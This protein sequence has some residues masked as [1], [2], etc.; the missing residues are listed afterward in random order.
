MTYMD[1][2]RTSPTGWLAEFVASTGWTMPVEK[3]TDDGVALVVD[4]KQAKLVPVKEM[5]SFSQLVPCSRTARIISATDGWFAIGNDWEEPV[6]GWLVGDNGLGI[7]LTADL[8][9]GVVAEAGE[10]GTSYTLV[11]RQPQ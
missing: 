1:T 9:S 2:V 11:R 8:D 4:R 5:A 10:Q 7:P 3:F 6:V